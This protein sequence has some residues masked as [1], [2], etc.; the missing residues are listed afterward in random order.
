M[1]FDRVINLK[2]GPQPTSGETSTTGLLI[3]DL[4][5]SFEITRSIT[6]SDNECKISIFNAKEDTI[7]NILKKGNNIRLEAGYED[8]GTGVV[9]TGNILEADT[10]FNGI[11][12]I[13]NITGGGIQKSQNAL[14][15]LTVSL[16]YSKDTV[17]SLPIKDLASILNLTPFGIDAAS[18]V[19][20]P[21]G[22]SYTGTAKGAL[23]Q[24]KKLLKSSELG[25]YIDNDLLIVYRLG[26]QDTRFKFAYLTPRSGL[27]N[28]YYKDEEYRI[29]DKV[30]YKRRVEYT[31]LLNP[32]LAPNGLVTI[33]GK[34]VDGTFINE[35]INFKGDNFGGEFTSKGLA[36]V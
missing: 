9:Y 17:L 8:E 24:L 23:Y 34:A 2:I 6:I 26:V 16:S 21:N 25:L 35:K 18:N 33:K 12:K 22:F 19:T 15:Y 3:S 14:G 36:L 29:G 32:N 31:C 7:N 5:I 4:N 20:A 13:T 1:A 28:A 10:T 11:D 27:I 30:E